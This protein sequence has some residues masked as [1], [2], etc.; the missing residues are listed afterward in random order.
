MR[1][2]GITLQHSAPPFRQ[3]ATGAAEAEAVVQRE[4][5]VDPCTSKHL[6]SHTSRSNS[7]RSR[8]RCRAAA[9]SA[10]RRALP[11][12]MRPPP[13]AAAVAAGPGPG[14]RGGD[15]RHGEAIIN[16]YI[17]DLPQ[18]YPGHHFHGC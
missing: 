6:V 13:W 2:G 1:S 10:P 11:A 15:D 5:Q 7:G 17:R 9:L 14:G 3:G 16:L 18:I 4:H 8:R 12:T